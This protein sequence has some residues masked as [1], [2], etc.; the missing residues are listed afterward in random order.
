MARQGFRLNKEVIG[1]IL[2]NEGESALRAAAQSIA[3]N[4]PAGELVSID[5]YT[6]DRKVIGVVV[7]ADS[8]AKNGVA[9]K[10]ASAVG[11]KPGNP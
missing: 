4:L 11:I 1:Q 8:Q 2:K 3:A 5:E 10:A 6:T 7:N 9:T